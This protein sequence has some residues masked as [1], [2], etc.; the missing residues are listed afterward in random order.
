MP[1]LRAACI[2]PELVSL[3]SFSG[4]TIGF[5]GRYTLIVGLLSITEPPDLAKNLNSRILFQKKKNR[6][7]QRALLASD[8]CPNTSSA[9]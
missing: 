5:P 3:D 8:A 4:I 1:S 9:S 2:W 7:K 6:P